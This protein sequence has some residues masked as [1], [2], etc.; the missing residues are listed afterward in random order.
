MAAVEAIIDDASDSEE[1]RNT[2][3]NDIV[4]AMV[5]LNDLRDRVPDNELTDDDRRVLV[6]LVTRESD[7][8]WDRL[9]DTEK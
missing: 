3:R 8:C 4:G 6:A 5:Y 9:K 1:Q 2:L 7:R